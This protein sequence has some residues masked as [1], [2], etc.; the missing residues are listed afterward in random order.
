MKHLISIQ[1]L[2][3]VAVAFGALTAVS[4]AQARSDVYFSVGVQVPGVFVQ[5][6]PVYVTPRTYYAP[7][8]IYYRGGNDGWRHG[9]PHWQS[10]GPY[11][12]RDRDGIA[13]FH[14]SRNQ[15]N[16]WRQASRFGPNGDVDR[17]GI[18]NRHDR[19]RDGDGA[20]NRYDRFPDSP[21]RR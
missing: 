20:R 21:N 11:G 13:N 12:D 4:S 17:D 1:S 3:A 16:Q 5:P 2:A 10:R 7:A 18:M 19:D 8:P 9:V 6:A 15:H 14:D